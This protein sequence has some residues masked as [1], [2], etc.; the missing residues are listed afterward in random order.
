MEINLINNPTNH[1]FILDERLQSTCL[2]L[3]NWP[4]S[5]V[6]L[7]NNSFFPWLILVPRRQEIIEVTDLSK[8]ER[9]QLMD[10]IHYASTALQDFCKPD[11]INI[12][13]L[14]NIVKQLHVHIV[15]RFKTDIEWPQGIWHANIKEQSYNNIEKVADGIIGRLSKVSF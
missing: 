7:K 14:G 4:L 11:K 12:G 15:A 5:Q 10:E 3:L 6:L 13:A 8:D 1:N 2:H 9:I